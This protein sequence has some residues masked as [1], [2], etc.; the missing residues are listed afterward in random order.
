[1]RSG[2]VNVVCPLKMSYL[3]IGGKE[4]KQSMYLASVGTF[5]SPKYV[6]NLY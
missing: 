6:I 4:R 5:Q 3:Y 2:Y 1:M